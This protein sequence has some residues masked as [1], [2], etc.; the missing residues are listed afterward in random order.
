MNTTTTKS[1]RSPIRQLIG[2]AF[3]LVGCAGVVSVLA[4]NAASPVV[5]APPRTADLTNEIAQLRAE[6][7]HLKGLVPD[8]AHAMQ[9]VGYH[10]TGLWF[11]GRSQ[12]WPLAQF[13]F[14]ETRSHLR[15]AVRIIP[16]RKTKGGDL[17]LKGILDAVERSMFSEIQKAIDTK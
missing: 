16:V 7:E 1:S 17:E 9:D 11:A 4:Q 10:F 2:S 3:A 5:V 15:W 14:G 13:Y 12:N 8:Q 6:I